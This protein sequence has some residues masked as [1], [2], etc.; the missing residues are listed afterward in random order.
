MNWFTC[1]R[2]E[3]EAF[4]NIQDD[5]GAYNV[6]WVHFE[7]EL[8][9]AQ[10]IHVTVDSIGGCGTV[11]ME[12]N[13]ILR[14]R[15]TEVLIKRA[16]SAGLLV[17]MAGKRISIYPTGTIM[18]HPANAYA[19]GDAKKLRANAQ[20]LDDLEGKITSLLCARTGQPRE[21]VSSWR[22][23]GDVYF[24][25]QEALKLNLVDEIV[26]GK[27]SGPCPKPESTDARAPIPA[28]NNETEDEKCF[29]AIL[30]GFN[31]LGVSDREGFRKNLERWFITNVREAR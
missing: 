8:G 21:L 3:G 29:L 6:G 27:A 18:A 28:R 9:E 20:A 16:Y 4:V 15:Y 22:S 10:K 17:A 26:E 11:A 1:N 5:I 19:Y 12:V 24:S 31:D 25:A 14:E 2:I 13:R 30:S 7:R 23:N